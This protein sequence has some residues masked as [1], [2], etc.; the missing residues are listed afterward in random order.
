MT[1]LLRNR[2]GTAFSGYD[3]NEALAWASIQST[4]GT[5]YPT[6]VQSA[7]ASPTSLPGYANS[8][9][10]ASCLSG[11]TYTVV[12]GD[13]CQAIAHSNSVATGTLIIINQI[14]PGCTD[15]EVGQTLCLPQKCTTITVTSGDTCISIAATYGLPMQQF[16]AWNPSINSGCTNLLA[17]TDI[18]VSIPGG[19]VWNGTTVAGA[20]GAQTAVYATSTVAPAG[21]TALGTTSQCGKYY[22]VQPGDICEL[23]ALNNTILVPLFEAINPSVNSSCGNLVPGLY[24]CVWP[25]AEWNLTATSNGT[26]TMTTV[27]APGPTASGA[28]SS[29]YRWYVV[30]SGDNCQLIEQ[31]YGVTL[32]QLQAW[33]P[34][35]NDNCT[36]LLADDAYCVE[37]QVA[38]TGV[39]TVAPPGPTISGKMSFGSY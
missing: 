33:N 25:T 24:Y 31:E 39:A 21:P 30:Q 36:N 29:C 12:S 18:C 6:A 16:L 14:L 38:S 15:I 11:N 17:D 5:S 28:S 3:T 19:E 20:T 23:I 26:T 10:T 37:G 13:N 1:A 32:A 7:A 35:I 4:C 27:S 8:S 2:Q 22:D 34:S 9:Y